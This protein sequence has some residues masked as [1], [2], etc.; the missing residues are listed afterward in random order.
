M[1]KELPLQIDIKDYR[2][3]GSV[4]LTLRPGTVTAVVG[5]SDE[6]KSNLVRALRSALLTGARGDDCIRHGE[7][8]TTVSITHDDVT[9]SW[10]KTR[11]RK[12][13]DLIGPA[14]NVREMNLGTDTLVPQLSAQ[15]D[16]PFLLGSTAGAFSVA[17]GALSGTHRVG[18]AVQ[19]VRKCERTTSAAITQARDLLADESAM[20]GEVSAQLGAVTEYVEVMT[21]LQQQVHKSEQQQ[22]EAATIITGLLDLKPTLSYTE[23]GE[24]NLLVVTGR[25]MRAKH[26]DLSQ[27]LATTTRISDEMAALLPVPTEKHLRATAHA[28]TGATDHQNK[29]AKLVADEKALYVIEYQIHTLLPNLDDDGIA[30][31]RLSVSEAIA[32]LKQIQDRRTQKITICGVAEEM[33]QVETNTRQLEKSCAVSQAEAD[34]LWIELQQQGGCPFCGQSLEGAHCV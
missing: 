30:L 26:D 27:R 17:L 31:A 19:S 12:S 15:T 25:G 10:S 33:V 4:S 34:A 18:L 22:R 11:T 14:L 32:V 24:A 3:L 29:L 28:L 23:L 9:H 7:R 20:W 21:E 8:E 13:T 1:E 16:P 5:A 6:G 2:S